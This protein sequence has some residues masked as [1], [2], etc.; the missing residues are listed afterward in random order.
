[1]AFHIQGNASELLQG[2]RLGVMATQQTGREL[3]NG[4]IAAMAVNIPQLGAPKVYGYQYDQLNRLVTMDVFDGLN[5]TNNQF[6]PIRLNDYHEKISYDANG[7]IVSYLRNGATAASGLAMDN[8][9]YQYDYFDAQGQRQVYTPG[10]PLPVGDN[11]FTNRLNHVSDP[12]GGIY[13]T[14]IKTQ[15]VNNYDYDEIGNLI[16]DGTE[17]ITNI[18]WNVYGK[19]SSIQKTGV[20]TIEYTYD[21]SGDRI[22]KKVGSKETWYVRDASGNVM[23]IYTV[24]PTVNSSHL[25][26]S[27]IHLYGSSRLGVYNVNTDMEYVDPNSDGI[28]KFTRGN[29]FFELSNHLGN[30]LVTVSDKKIGVSSNGTTIDYY[31]ADVISATDYYPFG[32]TMPGRSYGTQGRYSFNG[33]EDDKEIEGQQDYGFRIYDKRL[34]RFKSVDPL[35]KKFPELTPYQFASNTPI[36]AIDLDGLEA[37]FV[38]GAGNDVD[39]WNYVGR[40]K[41]IFTTAGISDFTRLNVS[42]GKTA[43]ILFTN[44]Y[45]NEPTVGQNSRTGITYNARDNGMVQKA[46]KDVVSNLKEGKQLNLIGYSY[47]S[48]IQAY[49]AIDLIQQGYKVDNLVLIG[50]PI[51]DGSTTMDILTRYQSEGKIGKIIR[52]DIPGDHLSNPSNELEFI[53]GGWQNRKDSG[54][55]FDLA[56]PDDPKTPKVDE[57]KE[58]DAKIKTVAEKLKK[59]GVE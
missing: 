47:G 15:P 54:P 34:G 17:N 56:R 29:K 9:N 20:G 35:T 7:N 3:F 8:M 32:M 27:E 48:V 36:R 37:F 1:M 38:A 2:C 4:N 30:V 24:D 14:D 50:S 31:N 43:D 22:S 12:A 52:Y 10:Q 59:E 44:T 45:R 25:T 51:S 23:S 11:R 46:V 5:N 53:Y 55:H 6:T 57:G 19:I 58:A 21:A 16:K 40:F 39:G 41:N 33:K 18:E 49:T 28:S 13:T 42:N 26:Q